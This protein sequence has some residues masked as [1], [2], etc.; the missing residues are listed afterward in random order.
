MITKMDSLKKSEK[1]PPTKMT[2]IKK[3]I[4]ISKKQTKTKQTKT[5][6]ICKCACKIIQCTKTTTQKTTKTT[7]KTKQRLAGTLRL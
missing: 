2:L 3:E 6:K 5:A 4:W 1:K 7:K